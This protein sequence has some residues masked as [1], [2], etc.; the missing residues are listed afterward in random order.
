M[1]DLRQMVTWVLRASR[2]MRPQ[3][4]R[5]ALLD[6]ISLLGWFGALAGFMQLLRALEL[7]TDFVLGP[8]SMSLGGPTQVLGVASLLAA[9]G[10]IG[11]L[12][13]Y[14]ARRG[15]AAASGALLIDLRSRLLSLVSEQ[16][17]ELSSQISG[18]PR[19]W[20]R[21]L[22]AKGSAMTALGL[23][24]LLNTLLPAGI[25]LLTATYLVVIDPLLSAMLVPLLI[26]YLGA[27]ALAYGGVATAREAYLEVSPKAVG[28]IV[29]SLG[30]LLTEDGAHQANFEEATGYLEADEHQ[31]AVGLF[32]ELRLVTQR[33]KMINGMFL[34]VCLAAVLSFYIPLIED[35]ERTWAD[36]VVYVIGLRLLLLAA[37][38]V[39]GGLAMVSRRLPEITSLSR[40]L[41][42]PSNEAVSGTSPTRFSQLR[43]ASDDP[44]GDL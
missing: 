37:Q 1:R 31:A 19:K 7:D 16:S 14:M 38:K 11:A 44:E 28:N 10:G 4:V 9:L 26:P 34:V 24:S 42:T 29:E 43:P 35:T 39:S 41:D 27:L 2:A 30:A 18:P 33:V 32:F 8:I 20:I 25:V 36:P 15:S 13:N 21:P 23:W 5:V 6:F 3:I 40:F 22:V 17:H 12:F